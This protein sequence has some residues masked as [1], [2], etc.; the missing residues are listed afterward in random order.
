M[1]KVALNIRSVSSSSRSSGNK[2]NQKLSKLHLYI[3][4][5]FDDMFKLDFKKFKLHVIYLVKLLK[6]IYDVFKY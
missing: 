1:V 5:W 3:D 6:L 2:V 4:K